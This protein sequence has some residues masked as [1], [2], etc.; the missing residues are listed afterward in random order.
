MEEMALRPNLFIVG[1]PKSGTT[2]LREYLNSH[3]EI[4]MSTPKEPDFFCKD[5]NKSCTK[6]L[7]GY[8]ELFSKAKDNHKFLGEAS[9]WYLFSKIAAK[10]IYRFNPDAKIIIMLRNPVDLIYSLH[11]QFLW[12]L[13]EEIE[14]FEEAWFCQEKRCKGELIPKKCSEPQFL[15]YKAV[16]EFNNQV[17]RYFDFFP[18]DQ[19]KIILFE[20]FKNST[21]KIYK[22]VLEFISVTTD[23]IPDLKAHN[24]NRGHKS[25]R[26]ASFTQKPPKMVVGLLNYVKKI[27][28]IERLNLM[29]QLKKMNSQEFKR[30]PLSK[31]FR[32]HLVKEFR[33]DIQKLSKLIDRRLDHWI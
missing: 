17:E 26:L 15:Q 1:A 6:N 4:F 21:D 29:P 28:K 23:V 11:S 8:L 12:T 33:D 13:D 18:K 14:N 5:F 25:I 19:I 30:P 20:D 22:D 3:N 9:V 7:D 32:G 27:F 16:G 10:E 2:S 31:E 24:K